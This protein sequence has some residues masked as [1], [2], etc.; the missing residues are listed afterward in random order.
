MTYTNPT[1]VTCCVINLKKKSLPML[2]LSK[3]IK[4][5]YS[6]VVTCSLMSSHNSS[7]KFRVRLRQELNYLKYTFHA[8]LHSDIIKLLCIDYAIKITNSSQKVVYCWCF[9]RRVHCQKC[10]TWINNFSTYFS[11]RLCRALKIR[12]RHSYEIP[13]SPLSH[14]PLASSVMRT[15]L[16]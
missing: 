9:V 7:H 11:M 4:K 12:V 16:N 1:L 15:N 14:P 8:Y 13:H 2:A 6:L 10:K 5:I 3:L